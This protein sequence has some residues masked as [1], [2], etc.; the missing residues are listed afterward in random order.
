[1]VFK[2]YNTAGCQSQVR[3]LLRQ[4]LKLKDDIRRHKKK[5]QYHLDK[6]KIIGAESLVEVEKKLNFYLERGK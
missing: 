6:I 1:M 3:D 5:I 4:R 2:Q